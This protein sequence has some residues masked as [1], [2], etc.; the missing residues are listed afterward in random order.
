MHLRFNMVLV[1]VIMPTY[2]TPY[3]HLKSA[4]ESIKNQTYNSFELLIINDGSKE[5]NDVNEWNKIID[6]D[7]RIRIINNSHKKGVAGS[8]N[9][10]LDNS[11]GKYIIRM[12]ADD[13]SLPDRISKQVQYMESHEDIDLL[14]GYTKCFGASNKIVKPER[15]DTAIR[16]ALIFQCGLPHPTICLRK[17]TL[18]KY[19]LFY[20]EGVQ[21]E[22]YELWTRCA[23]IKDFRFAALP[24]V[25]LKYRIHEGQ[26]SNT[27]KELMTNQG[28]AIRFD[29]IKQLI[30]NLNNDELYCFIDYVMQPYKS[31]NL[32]RI[33]KIESTICSDISKRFFANQ[34]LKCKMAFWK[35][36]AK[37]AVLHALQG[38]AKQLFLAILCFFR[39]LF[40]F[41]PS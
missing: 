25:L 34:R 19:D 20:S 26:V 30:K 6:S 18:D 38:Q 10:G 39:Y 2:N 33:Y 31:V 23:L 29:Y 37:K 13:I 21:S 1:S 16:T 41:I 4:V 11:K 35:I 36:C 9:T 24:S 27:R 14:A 12:D 5:F 17:E 22:D 8:L 28:R 15:K 3:E 32:Q 40:S 7:P